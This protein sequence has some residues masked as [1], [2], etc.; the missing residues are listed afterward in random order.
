MN[1]IRVFLDWPNGTLW[2][3]LIASAIW[4]VPIIF[5]VYRKFEC[6]DKHCHRIGWH[7]VGMTHWRTCVRHTTP[8][9]HAKLMAEHKK[10]HPAA[11][12]FLHRR[13]K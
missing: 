13:K 11:H 10:K 3:N 9:E 5:V 2:S 6:R 8:A 1:D 12:E 7:K 4:D